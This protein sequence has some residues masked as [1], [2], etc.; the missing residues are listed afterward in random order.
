MTVEE[1]REVVLRALHN[2]APE[3]DFAAVAG[4]VPLREQVDI[5]SV[6]YLRVL[7]TLNEGLHVDIPEDDYAKIATIDGLVGY[8]AGK[9]GSGTAA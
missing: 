5:D 7:V 3:V 9:V 1:I 4:D 6:D 8:L 2:V